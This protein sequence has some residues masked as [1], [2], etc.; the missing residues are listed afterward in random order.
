MF[1]QETGVRENL[2]E[3]KDKE[4][5]NYINEKRSIT[6][7]ELDAEAKLSPQEKQELLRMQEQHLV[8]K[9]FSEDAL[10]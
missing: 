9:G 6:E 5:I 4:V 3:K 10:A 8:G 1:E 2:L 7:F